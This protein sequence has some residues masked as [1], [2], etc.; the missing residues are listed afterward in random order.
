L[1]RQHPG[2]LVR[3]SSLLPFYLFLDFL[4]FFLDKS[5]HMSQKISLRKKL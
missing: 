1:E 5:S 3:P 2:D 4:D